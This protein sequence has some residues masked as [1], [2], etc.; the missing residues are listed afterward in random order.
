MKQCDLALDYTSSDK[1]SRF[2]CIIKKFYAVE[3]IDFGQ[4][5]INILPPALAQ[6]LFVSGEL[7]LVGV[8]SSFIIRKQIP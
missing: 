2:M 4:A 1:C 7:G 8:N 6:L 5:I 3:R